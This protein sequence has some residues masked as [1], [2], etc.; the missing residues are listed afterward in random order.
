MWNP[1][2]HRFERNKSDENNPFGYW[3]R[4]FVLQVSLDF[5]SQFCFLSI[6]P[7]FFLDVVKWTDGDHDDTVLFS[8]IRTHPVQF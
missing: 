8:F 7:W 1:V 3:L 6:F 5:D 2:K 4:V